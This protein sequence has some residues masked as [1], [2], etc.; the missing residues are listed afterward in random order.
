MTRLLRA[1]S[2]N[3]DVEHA[4]HRCHI[5]GTGT[6]PVV[7]FPSLATAI[8]FARLFWPLR[9]SLPQGSTLQIRWRFVR[10]QF[11][12]SKQLDSVWSN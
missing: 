8:Y 7:I 12:G 11:Q 3:L 1:L 6:L 4:G 2:F 10:I 5:G 9:K